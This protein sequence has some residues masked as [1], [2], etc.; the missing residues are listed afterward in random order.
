MSRWLVVIIVPTIP[1]VCQWARLSVFYF[2]APHASTKPGRHNGARDIYLASSSELWL[3]IDTPV[4]Q[5]FLQSLV[6]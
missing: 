2:H 5:R 4:Q 6:H 1:L 3:E